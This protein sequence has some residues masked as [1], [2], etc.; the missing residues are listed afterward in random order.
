VLICVGFPDTYRA[1][2]ILEIAEKTS[3][4]GPSPLKSSKKRLSS[5]MDLSS[6]PEVQPEV[7]DSAVA[8]ELEISH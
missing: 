3:K 6:V 8:A 7:P 2:E 4:P 1:E 5:E